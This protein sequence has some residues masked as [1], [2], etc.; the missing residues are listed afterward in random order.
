MLEALGRL[1][2]IAIHFP[3]AL[4][5]SGGVLSLCARLV[6]RED[7]QNALQAD[8]M[9]GAHRQGCS[10]LRRLYVGPPSQ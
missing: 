9:D 6:R 2:P 10:A 7:T 5:I 4:L 3:L 1:H 8:A